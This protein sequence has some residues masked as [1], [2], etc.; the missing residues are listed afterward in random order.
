MKSLVIAAAL[1][2]AA[3]AAFATVAFSSRSAAPA[4]VAA[5]APVVSRTSPIV[6][7]AL[8]QSNLCFEIVGGE[9]RCR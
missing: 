1:S 4:A 9:Y 2:F 5:A 3:G 7:S 6:A 8:T